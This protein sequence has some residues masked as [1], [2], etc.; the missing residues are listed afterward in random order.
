MRNVS[1]TYAFALRLNIYWVT[2]LVK[3]RAAKSLIRI[4]E[5]SDGGIMQHHEA[6]QATTWVEFYN[7]NFSQMIIFF[8]CSLVDITFS[9][10]K[11]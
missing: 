2:K 6:C 9:F 11:S 1:Y 4:H 8:S 5:E 3:E 7:R 10:D